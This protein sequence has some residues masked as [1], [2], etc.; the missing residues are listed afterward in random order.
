LAHLPLTWNEMFWCHF[1]L[2]PTVD[3]VG[4]TTIGNRDINGKTAVSVLIL[5][6]NIS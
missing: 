3:H 2:F 1:P 6:F 4:V 5:Y